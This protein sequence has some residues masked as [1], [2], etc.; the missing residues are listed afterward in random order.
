MI[1]KL[2]IL[3]I[4][5]LLLL[6]SF[7]C[8]EIETYSEIPEIKFKSFELSDYLLVDTSILAFEYIRGLLTFEFQ[9]GDGDFGIFLGTPD[10][11]CN[12]FLSMYEKVD[13]A[14]IEIERTDTLIPPLDRVIK[15]DDAMAREG[16]N[17]LL[18][19]ELELLIRYLKNF[20]HYDTIKY[21][22]YIEDRKGHKSN[23]ESTNDI[24]FDWSKY[25]FQ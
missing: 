21:E 6:L 23:I 4:F 14:F 7:S 25:K 11:V 17:K 13:G 8:K 2:Q 16:Q 18:K 24:L 9:D 20:P 15:Y 1:Q 12:L 19:G 10:T 5:S 3:A 22:F